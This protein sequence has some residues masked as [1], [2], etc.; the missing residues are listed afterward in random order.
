MITVWCDGRTGPAARQCH[1]ASMIGLRS[2]IKNP[3]K[4]KNAPFIGI[5]NFRKQYTRQSSIHTHKESLTPPSNRKHLSLSPTLLRLRS[6]LRVTD[7]RFGNWRRREGE[8]QWRV[9]KVAGEVI[10]VR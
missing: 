4:K 9:K 6:R 8:W 2:P 3:E 5:S 1:N 10:Q 7:F